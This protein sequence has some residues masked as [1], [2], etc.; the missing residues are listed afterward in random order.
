MRCHTL[1]IILNIASPH[2][3]SNGEQ[4]MEVQKYYEAAI[5]QKNANFYLSRF[6][7]FDSNGVGPSW[8]WPAFLFTFYWLLYRKMRFFALVYVLLPIPL[9][10]I[11][12]IVF[13]ADDVAVAV[14]SLLYLAA[15]F[16][17]LPMYANAL[18]Y[19]QVQTMIG[20]ARQESRDEE[21]VLRSITTGGG[22][23]SIARTIITSF[24]MIAGL[25]VV[26]IVMELR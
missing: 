26:A 19:R 24:V 13:P 25:V 1:T 16:I 7:H 5:G 22:T 18:Y 12:S 11:D 23:M 20:K 2:E 21:A 6:H 15:T 9:A 3:K 4:N 14:T 17:A 8:N 10:A